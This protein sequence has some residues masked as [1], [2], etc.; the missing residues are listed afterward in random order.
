[1]YSESR[2]MWQN[3]SQKGYSHTKSGC[4]ANAM[5]TGVLLALVNAPTR[6]LEKIDAN[7]IILFQIEYV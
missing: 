3:T 5:D 4:V 7:I 6:R 2:C 1:M